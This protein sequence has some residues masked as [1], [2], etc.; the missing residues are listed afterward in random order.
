M[1]NVFISYSHDSSDHR[2]KVLALSERLRADGI[3]T[4]L[5]QY[6]NGSPPEGWPRWMLDQLDAADFVLVICTETYYRRF[7]G[8]EVPGKG[9]GVDWEGALITQELYQARSKTLKFVPIFLSAA[10]EGWI[11]EPLRAGNYYAL[12]S[13][14]AYQSLYDFLLQQSGVEPGPVGK[15][16][17]KARQHGTPLSFEDNTV[18]GHGSPPAGSMPPT[19][20][21]NS[22]LPVVKVLIVSAS[23]KDR[24]P[25]GIDIEIREI[26][27]A[28][29]AARFRDHLQIVLE[30]AVLADEFANCLRD[31]APQILHFS[32][33]HS[34]PG[35]IMLMD[36]NN[37][38]K[39]VS[40]EALRHVLRGQTGLRMVVLNTCFSLA[41]AD[42]L[43]RDI[44]FVIGVEADYADDASILFAKCF[45]GALANGHSVQSA[46]DQA[47]TPLI[48]KWP[49]AN[50]PQLRTHK[51][52][53]ASAV[54]LIEPAPTRPGPSPVTTDSGPP[55]SPALR[56]WQ[57]KLL[58]LQVEEAKASDAEQKFAIQQRIEEAWA[59]IQE[60]GG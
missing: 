13:E 43:A 27:Q 51:R 7:R 9:K 22:S 41:G 45:Y 10:V 1:S 20:P 29:K 18:S 14:S 53:N 34:D 37:R 25:L 38:S 11:P 32:G 60:L 35:G 36:E 59:R 44:D 23:P 50:I 3:E 40:R 26:R 8:H 33:F 49:R 31:H 5:D 46:Y 55:A 52:I 48:G 28:V 17:R 39:P 21:A 12:T 24:D 54:V 56:T 58:F 19:F 57:K 42:T 4:L 16:K 2:E 15:P 30:T 47:I 6:M